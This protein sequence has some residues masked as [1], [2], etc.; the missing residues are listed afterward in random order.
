MALK[1]LYN[2]VRDKHL[3]EF[4]DCQICTKPVKYHSIF[5]NKCQHWIHPTCNGINKKELKILGESDSKWFCLKCKPNN[6][7][8]TK[9]KENISIGKHFAGD[10]KTY[11]KCKI[12]KKK[13]TGMNT[14]S[15][16]TCN[17]WIHKSCIGYFTNKLEYASFLKYYEDKEWDCP[18]CRAEMLPFIMLDQDEFIMELLDMFCKTTYVNKN[19]FKNVF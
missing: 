10:F 12:C 18:S 16:S 4:L 5:C 7:M 11:D 19:N 2:P 13:V 6:G 1:G 9:A 17:H 15:C 8:V 14:L 3:P